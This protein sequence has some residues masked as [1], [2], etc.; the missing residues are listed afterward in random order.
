MGSKH[1]KVQAV[2]IDFNAQ[3]SGEESDL[4]KKLVEVTSKTADILDKISNYKAKEAEIRCA[5]AT[6]SAET[7]EAAWRAII[8]QVQ[9]INSFFEFSRSMKT[10]FSEAMSVVSRTNGTLSVTNLQATTVQI[11]ELI[12][13]AIQFDNK[14]LMNPGLQN[15]FSYYRRSVGKMKQK[16]RED[17]VLRDDVTNQISMFFAFA[18]PM[19]LCLSET[20]TESVKGGTNLENFASF[21]SVVASSCCG[22]AMVKGQDAVKNLRIMTGCILL[23]DTVVPTGVFN[24]K[25]KFNILDCVRALKGFETNRDE[26]DLLVNALK[27]STKHFNDSDT[28]KNVLALLL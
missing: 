7:E 15:D 13:F 10:Q 23:Y 28:P 2:N 11:M 22:S 17:V 6:P 21:L 19:V 9:L 16:H 8:P 26:V 25:G 4:H 5:I 12:D 1:S 18:A 14:K 20:A 3:P 27:F 24:T